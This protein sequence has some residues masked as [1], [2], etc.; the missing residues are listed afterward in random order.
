MRI[1]PDLRSMWVIAPAV[2][3]RSWFSLLNQMQLREH[4]G[5]RSIHNCPRGI[6]YRY[7]NFF[8]LAGSQSLFRSALAALAHRPFSRLDALGNYGIY[9]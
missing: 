8:R 4:V 3:D 5:G 1:W 7:R 6:S 9:E 2:T